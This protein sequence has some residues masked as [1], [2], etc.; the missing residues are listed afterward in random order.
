MSSIKSSFNLPSSSSSSCSC[1]YTSSTGSLSGS[2]PISSFPD[3]DVRYALFAYL[4]S[5][6]EWYGADRTKY[7]TFQTE[8]KKL[9]DLVTYDAMELKDDWGQTVLHIAVQYCTGKCQYCTGKYQ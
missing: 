1:S 9:N 8:Y 2:E 7:V 5:L 4:R 6:A 3:R